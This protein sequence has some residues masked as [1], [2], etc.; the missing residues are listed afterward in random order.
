MADSSA[1]SSERSDPVDLDQLRDLSFAPQWSTASPRRSSRS[2]ESGD[3]R[4]PGP[5]RDRRPP[6]SRPTGPDRGKDARPRASRPP[7]PFKPVVGFSIFPEDEP[8][9]LLVQSM[10]STL[11]VYELFEVTRLILDKPDRM[12]VVVSPLS[13]EDPPLYESLPDRQIFRGEAAALRHAA[14]ILLPVMFDEKEEEVEPPTGKF[15]AVMRCGETGR[16]LPPKSYHRFQALLQEHHRTNCPEVPLSRV[17]KNLVSVSEAEAVE[18]WLASMSKRRVFRR[19]PE[20]GAGEGAAAGPA[21]D[22]REEAINH[23]IVREREKLVR[24]T[25]QARVPARALAEAADDEI[26]RSFEAYLEQQRRFPLDAANN[27]RMKLR[28]ANLF[29]FKKGKKGISFVSAV[30][31]NHFPEDAVFSDSVARI[32]AALRGK[33]GVRLKDLPGLLYPDRSPVEGKVPMQPEETRQLLN[34]LKWLKTEGY[35][36]EYGDGA[37]EIHAAAAH[38]GETGSPDSG[39]DGTAAPEPERDRTPPAG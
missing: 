1:S 29:L 3:H 28:K 39:A 20:E 10:R 16:L 6:R 36:F 31:R 9:D 21:F 30:R 19:R 2:D 26:R 27:V 32:I 13:E 18:E 7:E 34:D 24:E 5:P 22:S 11:K 17:E 4:P 25:R 14:A 38:S 12:V 23:L 15:P 33:S 35:L 37:L 8:F